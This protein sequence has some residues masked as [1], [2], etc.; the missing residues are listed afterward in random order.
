MKRLQSSFDP[1]S[2]YTPIVQDS[3]S[4]HAILN[5]EILKLIFTNLPL[6]SLKVVS[7]VSRCWKQRLDEPFWNGWVQLYFPTA[8]KK[9]PEEPPE[10]LVRRMTQ[11]NR[12]Y[13]NTRLNTFFQTN[14][15]YDPRKCFRGDLFAWKNKLVF[16]DRNVATVTI[17]EIKN[18]LPVPFTTI[19]N[20]DVADALKDTTDDPFPLLY[21][22][23]KIF[24]YDDG[25]HCIDLEK[26]SWSL[27]MQ[28]DD[29]YV[30]S[31]M[32]FQE[33]NLFLL[34]SH[35]E[36]DSQKY[37]RIDDKQCMTS[38]PYKNQ[39][40]GLARESPDSPS[41]FIPLNDHTFIV[42]AN[43]EIVM[44]NMEQKTKKN[45]I[46]PNREIVY[47]NFKNNKIYIVTREKE[48]L[49]LLHKK[50]NIDFHLFAL[51]D[52]HD[53]DNIDDIFIKKGKKFTEK[54]N[55]R[56][57]N[58]Q[59]EDFIFCTENNH[60]ALASTKSEPLIILDNIKFKLNLKHIFIKGVCYIYSDLNDERAEFSIFD[61]SLTEIQFLNKCAQLYKTQADLI[62]KGSE[63][64][65]NEY[66]DEGFSN[67]R[68]I[69]RD[70]VY[71]EFLTILNP[72]TPSLN[73]TNFDM[74]LWKGMGQTQDQLKNILQAKYD[75]ITNHLN[76]LRKSS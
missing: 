44:L 39:D 3:F 69:V 11:L 7:L 36:L 38:Y 43:H 29:S 62:S 22:S 55:C 9:Y 61:F 12:F 30:C 41:P 15:F 51:N 75:A 37:V 57:S 31:F 2:S 5:L 19:M 21:D 23:G 17:W 65:Q 32:S 74:N 14:F 4:Q 42:L 1:L 49:G 59:S 71:K 76:R 60:Y 40:F 56:F 73:A 47:I 33:G 48:S 50:N 16:F 64:Y 52:I 53:L 24:I 28:E 46:A 35:P 68:P 58:T 6:Q 72:S 13:A 8:K 70:A 63:L 27:I 34:L 66:C 45:F 18:G 54:Y 25:V 67:L 20:E 26:Q 10:E